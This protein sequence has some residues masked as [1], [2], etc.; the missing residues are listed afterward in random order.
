MSTLRRLITKPDVL[1]QYRQ[2]R[3]PASAFFFKTI[4]LSLCIGLGLFYGLAIALTL[5]AG[6]V[7]LTLPVLAMAA[8]VI[9]GLPDAPG[10]ALPKLTA[11]LLFGFFAAISLWPDYLSLQI[12]GL[13]WISLRRLFSFPLGIVLFVNLSQKYELRGRL[14]NVLR[15]ERWVSRFLIAFAICQV[16]SVL[17]GTPF[18]PGLNRW[19]VALFNWI[20]VL[21]AAALVFSYSGLS[22]RWMRWF[23]AFTFIACLVDLAEVHNQRLLWGDLLYRL[24]RIF[25]VDP[26]MA[27]SLL[28]QSPW[29]KYRAKGFFSTSLSFAEYM[30]LAAP[31]FSLCLF[32]ARTLG[33]QAAWLALNLLLI[34]A[35]FLNGSRLG[36]V[37]ALVGY[38][39]CAYLFVIQY[40]H[41]NP[42][43]VI[44][45]ALFY[46]LPIGALLGAIAI[47]SFGRLNALFFGTGMQILSTEARWAQLDLMPY[48]LLKR[49]LFGFGPGNGAQA[50]GYRSP[51]GQLT[52]DSYFI[53]AFLDYGVLG[54]IAYFGLIVT[55][56]LAAVRLGL[57]EDNPKRSFAMALGAA[58]IIYL[59]VRL[60]LSQ[61]DNQPLLFLLL[62]MTCAESYKYQKRSKEGPGASQRLS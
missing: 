52:V 5:P 41:E 7:P 42:R 27:D 32:R 6:A 23:C 57:K 38:S 62:G 53:S 33:G 45:S 15:S 14:W 22:S 21:L 56:I 50:L 47:K 1:P 11:A 28:R 44:A 46:L 48:T 29:T 8:V 9:W 18:V 26:E 24:P 61:E 40:R 10:A 16:L 30:A 19:I 3:S 54:G 51:G 37:G 60:V 2:L 55:G 13:P 39:T 31:F 35:L 43:H 17:T 34:S 58:L 36:L 49:P 59:I 20:S 4:Y 12:P 25:A